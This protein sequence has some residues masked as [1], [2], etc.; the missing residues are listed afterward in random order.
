MM[1][2]RILSLTLCALLL[3]TAL[4]FCVGASASRLDDGAD[5]LTLEEEQRIEQIL[6]Q[7]SNQH[8]VDIAIATVN[9]LGGYT[10][11]AYV[12]HYY[13][14]NGIGT[15]SQKDGALLLVCMADREYRILSNGM[16]GDAIDNSAID[17]IG[18]NIADHLSDG[19]YAKAFETFAQACSYYIDGHLNGFPFPTG[20]NM[21]IC[22]VVGLVIALIVTGIMRS[23][24]KSVKRQ[25]GAREYTKPGSMQLTHSSDLFLYRH[26]TRVKV[27]SNSSSGRSGG[28]RH[29]GG[30]RF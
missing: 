12:E 1:K 3:A 19:E 16:V 13:D 2:K 25:Q 5:L 26:V 10:P 21:L 27:Q 29:V 7:I 23:Q 6:D 8:G 11:D 20:R 15:G 14:S 4:P 24:L 18:D 30:G 17:S 28:S 9:T 22:L